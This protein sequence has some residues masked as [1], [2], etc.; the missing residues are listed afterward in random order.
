M[1]WSALPWD[2]LRLICLSSALKEALSLGKITF[3]D[4]NREK[5]GKCK[6]R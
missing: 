3:Y 6:V 4:D 5:G 2:E 1:W